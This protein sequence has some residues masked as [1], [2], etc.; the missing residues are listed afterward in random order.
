MRQVHRVRSAVRSPRPAK[1]SSE[2]TASAGITRAADIGHRTSDIGLFLCAL[3]ILALT[4]C[5]GSGTGSSDDSL[6]E[7]VNQTRARYQILDLAS[8]RLSAS[9]AVSDLLSNPAYRRTKLVFRL[10][11][12]SGT[13]GSSSG[14]LG[15]ALDPAASPA[16][17]A[18]FYLAVFETTQAQWELLAGGTPWAQ[19]TSAD[20]A[21]DVQIGDDYPAVGLS[22]DLV[23][24]TVQAYYSGVGARLSLPSDVQWELA[25]RAGGSGVWSWG[26]QTDGVTINAAAVVWE[27]SGTTR[28]ARTVAGRAPNALGLYD[29]HGNVWEM[30]GSGY[31]RG[32]SWNDP[33]ATARAAHRAPVDPSTRHLLVGARLVYVP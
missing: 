18:A 32:G 1:A 6:S 28:G 5:G 3:L 30:T 8:G 20:G 17:A 25:C 4:A 12:G 24:S 23:T 7:G 31:L 13:I 15:A 2:A 19:L 11:E 29:L 21:G 27:N 9:G 16:H 10:V 22:H 33:L 26:S 14:Q